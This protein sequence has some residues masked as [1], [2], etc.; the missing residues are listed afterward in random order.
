M[1]FPLCSIEKREVMQTISEV[2]PNKNLIQ[3]L[4]G[5]FYCFGFIVSNSNLYKTFMK[6]TKIV[7]TNGA[8]R[9]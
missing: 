5:F 7:E 6:I 4:W 3:F 2:V 1:F 8:R 9:R